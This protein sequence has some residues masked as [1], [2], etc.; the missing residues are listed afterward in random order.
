MLRQQSALLAELER[1]LAPSAPAPPSGSHA[2]AALS[3]PADDQTLLAER[4]EK[5]EQ[6]VAAGSKE[7]Q[8]RWKRLGPLRFGGDLRVRYE[9]ILQAGTEQRHRERMRFRFQATADLTE[10]LSA[11]FRITTGGLEDPISTNQSF[12]GFFARKPFDV[13]RAWISYRPA[14]ASW[15]T[16]TGGKFAVPW[17]RTELT[18]DNDLNPEGFAEAFSF[19]FD[20]APLTR[21]GVVAFQLPFNEV[22]SGKDSFIWGGQLQTELRLSERARLGFYAAGI[23]IRRAD[24]VAVAVA[25]NAIKPSLELSNRVVRDTNGNVIGFAEQFAYLDLIA[26]LKYNWRPRWPV[27]LTLDFVNNVRA[28][29]ERSGYWGEIEIG[30]TAEPGD[31]AVGYTLVRLEREA[32]VGPFNG[33]DFRSSTNLLNHRLHV[34]YQIHRH[35]TLEHM[36]YFGRLFNAQDNLDLVPV[37]FRPLNQDPY[38]KRFQFDVIYAF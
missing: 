34:A 19:T 17:Y 12:A 18:F 36:F 7:D 14:A 13:D 28:T 1:R 2:T 22:S 4:V 10:E 32:V 11:G 9:P 29:R 31:W 24:P 8:D 33:S 23:D 6:A 38:M 26:E 37:S 35:V 21:L 5:L 20:A 3:L 16:L 27:R 25:S 15:L 30:K